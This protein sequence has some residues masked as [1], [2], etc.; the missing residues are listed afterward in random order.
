MTRRITSLDLYEMMPEPG[1][2]I[3]VVNTGHSFEVYVIDIQEPPLTLTH[4]EIEALTRGE[5]TFQ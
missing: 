5:I 2:K 1:D 4:D 3:M